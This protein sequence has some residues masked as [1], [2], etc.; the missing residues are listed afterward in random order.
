M[1]FLWLQSSLSTFR[2]PNKLLVPTMRQSTTNDVSSKNVKMTTTQILKGST[3][4]YT[5][6]ERLFSTITE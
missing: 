2:F 4:I 3:H 5:C 1:T 6:C